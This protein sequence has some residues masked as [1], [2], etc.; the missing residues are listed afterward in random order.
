V[1]QTLYNLIAR[2]VEDTF[3]RCTAEL[4]M[5]NLVFNPVAGGLLTGKYRQDAGPAAGTR[6]ALNPVYTA[7]YWNDAQFAAVE[8]LGRIA[9]EAGTDLLSLSFRWLLSRPGVDGVILGVSSVEQLR[10]N[11]AAAA[12]PAP[13]ADVCMAIDEVWAALSGTAPLHY[14]PE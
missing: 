3:L 9:A 10:T 14:W 13:D 12:G 1:T 11:L 6:F 8:R 4:G 5:G 2:R 7:R